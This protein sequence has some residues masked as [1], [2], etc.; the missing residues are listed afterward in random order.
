MKKPTTASRFANAFG[1]LGY[2]SC[3]VQWMWMLA[4]AVFPRINASELRHLFVPAA[5][6]AQPVAPVATTLPPVV[7]T[8][9]LVAT[10][11]FSLAVIT[12]AIV[13]IPRVVGR[14]GSKLTHQTAEI[15]VEHV[16]RT[17]SKKLP[18][19]R[20]KTWLERITWSIKL[21]LLLLPFL[22]LYLPLP[23]E[24]P[25]SRDVTAA[26]GGFCAVMTLLWFLAQYFVAKLARLDPRNVW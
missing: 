25:L 12:Y 22:L 10:V 5:P 19:K 16:A 13:S 26:F 15:A 18:P 7:Q 3:L 4:V 9:V 21:G 6:A 24:S 20:K 14:A 23:P 11:V 17:S 8:I 1:A 2:I